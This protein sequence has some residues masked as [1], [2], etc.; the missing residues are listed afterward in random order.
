M[1]CK[2]V[3]HPNGIYE[4]VVT[5]RAGRTRWIAKYLLVVVGAGASYVAVQWL[6]AALL[7]TNIILFSMAGAFVFLLIDDY[8]T[9]FQGNMTFRQ[10]CVG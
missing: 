8:Y 7:L 5:N 10:R 9:V 6:V 1:H 4:C 2:T 3:E